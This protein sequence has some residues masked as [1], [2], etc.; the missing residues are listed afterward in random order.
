MKTT[1]RI[2]FQIAGRPAGT[3]ELGRMPLACAIERLLAL[4]PAIP[5]SVAAEIAAYVRAGKFE[6][7][8]AGTGAFVPVEETDRNTE[9]ESDE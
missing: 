8:A 3:V 1:T 7:S 4:Q 5:P 2:E 9:E 6:L